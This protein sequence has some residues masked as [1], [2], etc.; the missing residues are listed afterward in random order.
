MPDPFLRFSRITLTTNG[1]KP[2]AEKLDQKE[3]VTHQE[4]LM[5]QVLQL[6]AVTR[7]LI[8]KG[9]FTEGEF[10]GELKKVQAEYEQ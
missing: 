1:S 4:L 7:L 3:V 6:D 5:S 10:F 9:I 2:M 8:K